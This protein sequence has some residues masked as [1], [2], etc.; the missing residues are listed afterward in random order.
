MLHVR[1][2]ALV[3]GVRVDAEPV[4][5]AQQV[6]RV[7]LPGEYVEGLEPGVELAVADAPRAVLDLPGRGDHVGVGVGGEHRLVEVVEDRLADPAPGA[8]A[9]LLRRLSL[10][11]PVVGRP[12]LVGRCG[13]VADAGEELV[14]GDGR[15]ELPVAR[16]D[17]V[18]LGSRVG[19][20]LGDPDVAVGEVLAELLRDRRVRVENG[21]RGLAGLHAGDELDE[22][23][24]RSDPQYRGIRS[25]MLPRTVS[26]EIGGETSPKHEA[27]CARGPRVRVC[28]SW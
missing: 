3:R 11:R 13:I 23:H 18:P 24:A 12:S 22:G 1:R 28:S 4:L 6:V 17:G 7:R 26:A 2:V 19:P 16:E 10:E 25:F 15:D 20:F 9:D 14:D 21:Q 27:I 8:R 5:L